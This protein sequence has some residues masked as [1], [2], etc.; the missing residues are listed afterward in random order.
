MSLVRFSLSLLTGACLLV[1]NAG[2]QILG[3][4][5]EEKVMRLEQSER[6]LKIQ[7]R[8]LNQSLS[9]ALVEK[10]A[11]TKS[12]K[13]IKEHLALF[14]KDFFNGGD[15]KLRHAV[16]D[17]QVAR[18]KLSEV[19]ISADALLISLQAYLR[20]AVAA[21]PEAR[22]DVELKLRQFQV[23][24]GQRQQPKR[25]VE[26]G[27]VSQSRVMTVDSDSGILVINAGEKEELRPGMRYRIERAGTHIGDAIVAVTRPDVSGLLMQ[28][29]TKPDNVVRSGDAAHVILD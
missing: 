17:Y 22:A 10:E 13:E 9:T 5:L 1:S 19:E 12:L 28:T 7:V 20:T 23:A 8:S 24:L 3:E 15:E 16:S 26:Q 29:L 25:K 14:G 6:L 21:D 18:E 2:A 11:R 27:N 4:T